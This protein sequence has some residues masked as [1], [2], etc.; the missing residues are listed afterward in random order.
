MVLVELDY[1]SCQDGFY[2]LIRNLFFLT[3]SGGFDIEY[4]EHWGTKY[5]RVQIALIEEIFEV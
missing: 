5:I 2:F 4:C 3:G 1:V